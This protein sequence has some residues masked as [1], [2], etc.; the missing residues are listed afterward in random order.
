M[1]LKEAHHPAP[2]LDLELGQA[3]PVH[4]IASTRTV[5]RPRPFSLF[6]GSLE[7]TILAQRFG[8]D[9]SLEG[10]C[11]AVLTKGPCEASSRDLALD[12]V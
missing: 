11:Q 3:Q 6:S 5:G 7:P 10:H 1:L 2:S 9:H 8:C 12:K 4:F